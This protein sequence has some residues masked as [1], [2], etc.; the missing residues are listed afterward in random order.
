MRTVLYLIAC[1]L[2]LT[3][4]KASSGEKTGSIPQATPQ[5]TSPYRTNSEI[6]KAALEK[7]ALLKAYARYS[8]KE[9]YNYGKRIFSN[10]RGA[11]LEI[12]NISRFRLK[13]IQVVELALHGKGKALFEVAI[14]FTVAGK[15]VYALGLMSEEGELDVLKTNFLMDDPKARYPHFRNWKLIEKG[16]V[17]PGMKEAEVILSWGAPLFIKKSK[18]RDGVYDEWGYPGTFLYF[19][20]GILNTMTDF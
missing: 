9:L 11:P 13:S 15:P 19:K 10:Q 18:V 4:P 17:R 8:K 5:D 14:E 6:E 20:D 1:A 7:S 16:V 12:D 3:A 2:L